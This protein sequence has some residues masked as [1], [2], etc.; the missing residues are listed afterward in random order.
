MP[1]RDFPKTFGL[2]ELLQSYLSHKSKANINQNYEDSNFTTNMIMMKTQKNGE[3]FDTWY[4]TTKKG[5]IQF[6]GVME[7]H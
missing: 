5:S 7:A 1:L 4:T 3:E 2:T 6:Q